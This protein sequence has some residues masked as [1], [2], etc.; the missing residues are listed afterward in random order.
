VDLAPDEH[1]S[2]LVA[3]GIDGETGRYLLPPMPAAVLSGVARGDRPDPAEIEQLFD[4]YQRISATTLGP[5]EGVDPTDLAQTGW[6][7]I[8][9]ED[10]D[11]AVRA[12]LGKL[13]EHRQEVAGA[14]EAQRYQELSGDRGYQPGQSKDAFLQDLGIGPGPADPASLPY[15]LLLVGDPQ[16]IP[17]RFQYQLDVEYAVGRIDFDTVEEYERYADAVVRAETQPPKLPK[18]IGVFGTSNPDDQ[19]TRLSVERLLAP[20]V[21]SLR[22]NYTDWAVDVALGEQ[23]SKAA[24]GRFLGGDQ[25]PALLLSATHGLGLRNGHPR[26][27][28]D[29]GAI[30]CSEWPGPLSWRDSMPETFYFSG[31]DL[32]D[33]ARPHGML[34][35][36][37]ACFGAGTPKMDGFTRQAFRAPAPIAPRSFLASLPQRLLAHANG[38]ALAVVGHVD[39][40]WSYSYA[41]TGTGKQVVTFE[42]TLARL[43]GGHPIGSAME[44]FGQ[45]HAAIAADLVSALDSASDGEEEVAAVELA[46]LWTANNDARSYV[47]VGDPAVRMVT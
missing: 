3:N 5:K 14:H 27:L 21:T 40:A 39:R 47:V 1:A 37:F 34:A 2:L 38:G 19:A 25:T 6:G 46:R 16:A 7:V 41:W 20:L 17:F 23:A 11:P 18:R 22:T 12:A 28:Q 4:W 29:N 30:V 44:Y 43:M 31:D 36:L 26:Q 42:S 32:T 35:F 9:S 15:Y 24:F 10:A 45:R 13:L 8:F 33:G